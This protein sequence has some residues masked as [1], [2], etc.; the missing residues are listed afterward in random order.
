M[1]PSPAGKKTHGP[2][3]RIKQSD[4][5]RRIHST[6]HAQSL[7]SSALTGGREVIV[8]RSTTLKWCSAAVAALLLTAGTVVHAQEAATRGSA[9]VEP[10]FF[11]PFN[12]GPSRVSL[13]PFGSFDVRPTTAST[14]ASTPSAAPSPARVGDPPGFAVRA[15]VRPSFVP[16]RRSPF[17]P[18]GRPPFDPPGP[19]FDPPGPP[20]GTPPFDP[21]GGG[22]RF[23]RPGLPF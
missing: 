15:A 7:S 14:L 3:G 21:P 6:I 10:R 11:N 4:S 19:P 18:P 1:S 23:E 16:P 22:H 2:A 9:K 13:N 12:V 17:R 20:P 8:M 5:T